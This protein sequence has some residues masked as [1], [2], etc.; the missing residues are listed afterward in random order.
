MAEEER[1]L[2]G[3]EGPGDVEGEDEAELTDQDTTGWAGGH[4]QT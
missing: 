3:E 4:S 1:R 2:Y